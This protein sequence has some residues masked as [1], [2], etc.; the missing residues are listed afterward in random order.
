FDTKGTVKAGSLQVGSAGKYKDNFDL[1]AEDDDEDEGDEEGDDQEGGGKTRNQAVEEY[2]STLPKP[3]RN[4]FRRLQ[5]QE[6]Q[7]KLEIAQQLVANAARAQGWDDEQRM[8]AGEA[9]MNKSLEDLQEMQR[10]S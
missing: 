1:N 9:L 10:F 2:L 7:M 6:D 8:E 4:H 3:V 5:A